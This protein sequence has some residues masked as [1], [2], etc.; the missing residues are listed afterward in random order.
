MKS[1]SDIVTS[2]NR[3]N[4]LEVKMRGNISKRNRQ[5][6]IRKTEQRESNRLYIISYKTFKKFIFY[7]FLI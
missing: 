5:K 7:N 1:I 3:K 2:K 4:T 6:K